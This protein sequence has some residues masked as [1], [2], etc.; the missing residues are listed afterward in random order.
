MLPKEAKVGTP[1]HRWLRRQCGADEVV[2]GPERQRGSWSFLTWS[3]FLAQMVAAEQF[4]GSSA[5]AAQNDDASTTRPNGQS[6]IPL[7]EAAAGAR[8]GFSVE[9]GESEAIE[10]QTQLNGAHGALF[11]GCEPSRRFTLQSRRR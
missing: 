10:Q 9:N 5:R 1:N 7:E 4:F 8:W 2:K 3:F 6:E 11:P